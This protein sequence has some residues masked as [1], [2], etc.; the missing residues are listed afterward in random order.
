MT[1]LWQVH[2]HRALQIL[3]EVLQ[4]MPVGDRRLR[5]PEQSLR[6]PA[7]HASGR[8]T[9][10]TSRIVDPSSCSP[11]KWATGGYDIQN[12]RSVLLQSMPVGDRRLRHPEQLLRLPAVHASGRQTT[13][14]SRIVALS[15]LGR[16]SPCQL[17]DRRIRH[18]EKSPPLSPGDLKQHQCSQIFMKK[19]DDTLSVCSCSIF[20][21][22]PSDPVLVS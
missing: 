3:D 1:V 15:S 17:G 11:C 12:S 22:Q 2:L 10:T 21:L 19:Y 20:F 6:P 9:T 16:G 7:V 4:S 14:T 8:Q 13:T 18:L 5:H